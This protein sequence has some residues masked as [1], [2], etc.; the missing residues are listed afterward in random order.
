MIPVSLGS[1]ADITTGQRTGDRQIW[2][3]RRLV[4]I[5]NWNQCEVA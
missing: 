2:T 5:L 4:T 1:S 3:V